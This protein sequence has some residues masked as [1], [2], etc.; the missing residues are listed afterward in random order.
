MQLLWFGSKKYNW[1]KIN[2]VLSFI[3]FHIYV[4]FSYMWFSIWFTFHFRLSG[5]GEE[6]DPGDEPAE[7][8]QPHSAIRCIWVA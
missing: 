3:N 5:G 6:W 7:P 1:I 8:R 4:S 2:I